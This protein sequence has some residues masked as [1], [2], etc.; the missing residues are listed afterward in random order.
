MEK[1]P[2]NGI[3]FSRDWKRLC[4]TSHEK[5]Q[6]LRTIGSKNIP[7]IFKAEIS[8]GLLGE[9]LCCLNTE[10][11]P[12]IQ[13]DSNS[14]ASGAQHGSEIVTEGEQNE[15]PNTGSMPPEEA[16]LVNR[17]DVSE[18]FKILQALSNAGRFDL[19]LVFLSSDEKEAGKGV[20]E[21]LEKYLES[22]AAADDD[23]KQV[24]FT[25][26]ELKSLRGKYKF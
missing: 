11:S 23:R 5:Y 25:Q 20:F 8:C 14:G 1:L 26:Q 19:S 15:E 9:F 22:V 6:F 13:R 16:N 7:E 18:V 21:K 17:D 2:I 24:D 3:E 4:K 12:I 10:F